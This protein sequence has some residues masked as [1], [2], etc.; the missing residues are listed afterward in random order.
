MRAE[1]STGLQA[2]P[3]PL[4]AGDGRFND[5]PAIGVVWKRF[6]RRDEFRN[7]VIDEHRSVKIPDKLPVTMQ[8]G[9]RLR[10]EE[11]NKLYQV[12]DIIPDVTSSIRLILAEVD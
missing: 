2:R 11:E 9:D 7:I 1:Q 12:L 6:T 10:V 3:L 8:V 4:Y 5:Y